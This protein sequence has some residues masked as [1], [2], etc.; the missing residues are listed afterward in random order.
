MSTPV[1]HRHIGSVLAL[2]SIVNG[3]RLLSF[4]TTLE[5]LSHMS[6]FVRMDELHP[7]V[8]AARSQLVGFEA[9]Q[10]A[11]RSDPFNSTAADSGQSRLIFVHGAACFRHT[12]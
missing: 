4:D 11:N 9:G 12:D 5:N 2:Q 10:R 6:R 3:V 7:A 8:E 1:E